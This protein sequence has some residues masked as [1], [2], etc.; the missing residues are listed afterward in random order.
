MMH[1]QTLRC[2][3]HNGKQY[4][5][6]YLLGISSVFIMICDNEKNV[7][8]DSTVALNWLIEKGLPKELANGLYSYITANTN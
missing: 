3:D 7:S 1:R 5:I 4:G 2:I 6:G 8:T